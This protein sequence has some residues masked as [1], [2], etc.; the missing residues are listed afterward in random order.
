MLKKNLYFPIYI[1]WF[2]IKKM[3]VYSITSTIFQ[4]NKTEI[5]ITFLQRILVFRLIL[6]FILLFFH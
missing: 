5:N 6:C 3:T 2:T 4:P 1:F